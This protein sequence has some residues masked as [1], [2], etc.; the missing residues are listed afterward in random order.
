MAADIVGARRAST[1]CIFSA[2]ANGSC[3]GRSRWQASNS[4]VVLEAESLVDYC[5]DFSSHGYER[6]RG[7]HLGEYQLVKA[8]ERKKC[9]QLYFR[10]TKRL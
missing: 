5:L 6:V 4:L 9:E 8:K 7:V 2:N 10:Q 1:C 3:R